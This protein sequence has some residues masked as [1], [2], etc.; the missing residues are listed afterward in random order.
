MNSIDELIDKA[1]ELQPVP[2]A[3][4]EITA[5]VADE[6]TDS[7]DIAEV[8][9]YDQVITAMVLKYANS[10][11]S[12][13]SKKI[14]SV[15]TAVVR[16]GGERI[17]KYLMSNYIKDSISGSLPVYG[18]Q[19][20]E[21]WEHSIASAIA[22]EIIGKKFELK[23][24]HG[25]GFTASILHDFGKLV[26][27]KYASKKE[28][29]MVWDLVYNNNKTV[30]CRDAEKEILGYDHADLGFRII[31]KWNLPVEV[32][33]AVKNHHKDDSL[34]DELTDLVKYANFIAKSAGKGIG[35]EGMNFKVNTVYSGIVNSDMCERITADLMFELSRVKGMYNL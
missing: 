28:M 21:L 3:L 11:Y 30:S 7:E 17:Q 26:L 15:K 8:I 12:A 9:R 34:G 18:Y 19:E 35:Y 10:A 1:E 4:S 24:N 13:S 22:S 32:S 29:E 27:G 31:E 16:L 14:E 20:N 23:V 6:K 2:A 33:K 5:R 25:S